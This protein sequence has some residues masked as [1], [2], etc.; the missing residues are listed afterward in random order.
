MNFDLKILG[1]ASA[2][3]ISDKNP[4]AQALQVQGRLF[5]IDCGEGTQQRMRQMHLSFLKV[6]AVFLS[7]I[8]GDHLF[9]IFGLLST[10]AM[11][12]RSEVLHIFAP[13][14]FAPVLKFFLSYFGEGVNY[15][16]EHHALDCKAPETVFAKK[17]LEVTAFPLRHKIDCFG[18]RFAEILTARQAEKHAPRS[19]AYCSDTMYFPELAQW[20]KGVN[21]L[22]HEATYPVA[23]ADKAAV[24]FHS[25]THDAARTA[26][27]AG[28]GKLVVGHYTSR[29]RD[30]SLFEKE[31][32]EIFPLS[33]AANDG[34]VFEID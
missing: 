1:T 29:E 27:E 13:A 31:C 10:M 5:L 24:R 17:N 2:M 21:L 14:S 11:Y 16:I 6:E 23:L 25:T 20:V 34:D 33:F 8:H 26:L 28:V 22:Y 7:H 15:P 32:R 19:F 30:I 3:P 18:F 12:G 9:G 4:S